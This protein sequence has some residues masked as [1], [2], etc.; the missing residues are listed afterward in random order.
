LGGEPA[1]CVR[2]FSRI[3]AKVSENSADRIH[4]GIESFVERLERET[5]LYARMEDDLI[6]KLNRDAVERDLEQLHRKLDEF[7]QRLVDSY[8]AVGAA[9][10]PG[11][12]ATPA[13]VGR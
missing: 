11:R 12:E 7:E 8:P 5:T 2:Q 1:G 6:V 9:P 3:K 13:S 10:K 4:D